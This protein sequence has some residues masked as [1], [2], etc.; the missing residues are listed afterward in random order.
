MSES[1]PTKR[2]AAAYGVNQGDVMLYLDAYRAA[3]AGE[4]I[5]QASLDA[6]GRIRN[7]VPDWV[8]FF[9][10]FDA[11]NRWPIAYETDTSS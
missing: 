4:M 2:L 5:R 7:A 8:S 11:I 9:L 10:E 3:A 1:Y 6:A